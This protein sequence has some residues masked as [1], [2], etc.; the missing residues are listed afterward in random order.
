MSAVRLVINYDNRKVSDTSYGVRATVDPL[1][2]P[3]SMQQCLLVRR[4]TGVIRENLVRFASYAEIYTA[5]VQYPLP[6]LP[7]VVNRISSV[8]KGSIPSSTSVTIH[9]PSWWMQYF[10]SSSSV[11][12]TTLDSNGTLSSPL[13]AYAQSLRLVIGGVSYYDGV[14]NRIYSSAS[15]YYRTN[16]HCSEWPTEDEAS[17]IY[18]ALLATAQP[19]VDSYNS[20][21]FGLQ[22]Q[23]VYS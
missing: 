17:N 19:L 1:S 2:V 3:A 12:L 13:P 21:N 16:T 11:T 23:K 8:S 7:S 22:T 5:T 6:V 18:R 14:A 10:G 20:D 9:S 4:G 15:N